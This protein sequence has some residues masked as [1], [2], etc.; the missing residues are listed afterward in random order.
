MVTQNYRIRRLQGPVLNSG[1]NHGNHLADG[2][3][4]CPFIA[5]QVGLG[6]CGFHLLPSG[7]PESEPQASPTWAPRE[8]SGVPVS[9]PPA[10]ALFLGAGGGRPARLWESPPQ[11]TDRSRGVASAVRCR[12]SWQGWAGEVWE[13]RGP[14]PPRDARAGSVPLCLRL[15]RDRE[16]KRAPAPRSPGLC[17]RAQEAQPGEEEVLLL[18]AQ[19]VRDRGQAGMPVPT[20]RSQ[21]CPLPRFLPAVPRG[22]ARSVHAVSA[23]GGG[24]ADIGRRSRAEIPACEKQ[25]PSASHRDP[26]YRWGARGRPQRIRRPDQRSLA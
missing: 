12:Q 2:K 17:V 16:P 11:G 6:E 3:P 25:T 4:K 22:F 1:R 21:L 5:G 10:L 24:T 26:F 23:R 20:P 9:R 15:T 14:E 13:I 7:F 18:V 8:D 19:R